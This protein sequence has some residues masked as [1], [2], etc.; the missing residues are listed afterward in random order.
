[1][2]IRAVGAQLRTD[3]QTDDVTKLIV[4]FQNF[5]KGPKHE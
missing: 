1:M 5:A 3:G 4:A 2:K